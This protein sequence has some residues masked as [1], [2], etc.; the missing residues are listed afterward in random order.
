MTYQEAKHGKLESVN[1]RCKDYIWIDFD[2]KENQ[3]YISKDTD[4]FMCMLLRD[5]CLRPA[6]YECQAKRYRKADITIADFG[7]TQNVAP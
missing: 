4:T 6:C 7:G 3:L 5:Y 2:M 1:F